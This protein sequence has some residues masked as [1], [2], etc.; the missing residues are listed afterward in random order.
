[1]AILLKYAASSNQHMFSM[2]QVIEEPGKRL[3]GCFSNSFHTSEWYLLQK[4]KL[5]GLGLI[6]EIVNSILSKCIYIEQ[7][8]FTMAATVSIW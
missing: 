1:M 2:T 5:P 7:F 6:K 3:Q 8:S 4:V